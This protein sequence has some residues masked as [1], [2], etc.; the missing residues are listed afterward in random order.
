MLTTR[1]RGTS[2]ILP[3]E[4]ARWR[5]L[6]DQIRLICRLYGYGEIRTPIFEHTELIE[7]SVGETSDIVRKQTY[8][9]LDRGQRSLTLRPEGTAPTVRAYL[10]NKLYAR[11]LPVKLYYLAPIFR[12]ERPQAGRYRQHHQFGVEML[13]AGDPAADAEVITLAMDLCRR[14]GLQGL[15]VHL[16]SIGCPGCRP[17]YRE[18]LLGYFGG[19]VEAMCPDCRDRYARNPLRLLDCKEQECRR[20]GAQAPSMLDHLCD[21]CRGHFQRLQEYLDN[22]G[23]RWALDTRLVRGLDYY[24]RTVFE[25]VSAGLG[26]SA[27]IGGGGRYDGLV[28]ELGGVPT[29][30]IGFGMGL[31]RLLLTME[32]QG[33]RLADESRPD[34]FVAGLGDRGFRRAVELVHQ[35]RQAAVAADMDY[36]GRSLKA[37]MKYAHRLGARYVVFLGEEEMDKGAATL[38]NMETGDQQEVPLGDLVEVLRGVSP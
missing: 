18:V 20:L 34:A 22:L 1:P 37:Q 5:Y 26:I 33:I 6:E 28:E 9:F 32:S 27:A 4:A 12:H 19:L 8:T 35:L 25:I 2:D 16:N 17:G 31:E 24:T 11:T 14:L 36:L 23:I 21:D 13:G 15:T 10:E 30:G 7:R 3:E 38:R 29:P